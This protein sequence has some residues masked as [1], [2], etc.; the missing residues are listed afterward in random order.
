[1]TDLGYERPLYI[2]PFDHRGSF[3][4]GLFGWTGALSREQTERVAASKAIIYDGLLAA[5]GDGVPKDR[6]GLLVDEQFGAAILR[7][8]RA[9]GFLTAAPAE[10]SGQHEFDFEYGDDYARHIEAFAPTFCKVLVR[11]NPEGDAAMNRRQAGRLRQLSEYLHRTGRKFMFELLV[12]AEQAELEELHGDKRAYD[13]SR[14]PRHMVDAIHELQDAGVEPDVWKI[15]G[16]DRTEDCEAVVAVARRAGRDHVSCIVLGRGEDEAK[17]ETWLSTAARVPG[18]IGFAVGRTTFWDALVG[19]R[20][21]RTTAEAASAQVAERYTRWCKLFAQRSGAG[22]Q[23]HMTRAAAQASSTSHTIAVEHVKISSQRSF[24]EVRRR[25]EDTL[26]RLDASI[27]EALR[28]GDQKRAAEYEES[29]PKLS[30]FEE[31]DHGAL[32]QASGARRNALQYE[33]GNPVTASRMTRYQLSAAL[34]APLRVV[35]FQDEDGN[36]VFEYDR[37]SSFF[38]QYGDER[39]TE[40]GRYLDVTLE[41]ALR[42]AAE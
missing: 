2:L 8:A 36:G 26:P 39:V 5:V 30:I 25:L 4:S 32:L 28:S 13:R 12:P 1:M 40:V 3:E 34:Y 35:L 24:A 20:D 15:E 38:G 41:S 22:E 10:K 29:G 23:A 37:P 17:V 16:L 14:R 31:R 27:A 21:G 19:W 7:D 11:Y 9:R 18:F 42:K 33:I 6:A